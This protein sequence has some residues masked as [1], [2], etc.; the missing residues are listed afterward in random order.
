VFEYYQKYNPLAGVGRP[1]CNKEWLQQALCKDQHAAG[2]LPLDMPRGAILLGACAH[3]ECAYHD[4]KWAVDKRRRTSTN[5]SRQRP[6]NA[7]SMSKLL[8][9]DRRL[10]AVNNF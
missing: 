4:W 7:S 1:I 5:A 9:T 10:L 6:N 2:L 3:A 8:F